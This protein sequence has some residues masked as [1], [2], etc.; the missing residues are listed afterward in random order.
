[1]II[2]PTF[3]CRVVSVIKLMLASGDVILT[4][5]TL[6]W[7][8][9]LGW[10]DIILDVCKFDPPLY[11][12]K[13]AYSWLYAIS[14][15]IF[16]IYYAMPCS[17]ILR[18]ITNIANFHKYCI[19]SWILHIFM[20]IAYFHGHRI[21]SW[22]SHI[23]MDIAYFHGHRRFSWTSQIFVNLA[24]FHEPR[25]FLWTACIFMNNCIFSCT[26]SLEMTGYDNALITDGKDDDVII[27]KL[28]IMIHA[29][30]GGG[31]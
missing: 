28:L 7:D 16:I 23:F 25:I 18:T 19:F 5:Y 29:G 20:N 2:T 8:L 22:T 6:G 3:L 27:I 14:M 30:R 17:R 21:F 31:R 15:T 26:V 9:M 1:M 13:S 11:M 12:W 10:C 24:Y 4:M